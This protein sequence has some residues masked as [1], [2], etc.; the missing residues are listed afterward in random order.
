MK[1][2]TRIGVKWGTECQYELL[3]CSLTDYV[4]TVRVPA[5]PGRTMTDLFNYLYTSV[6]GCPLPTSEFGS[7]CASADLWVWLLR[8]ADACRGAPPKQCPPPTM[9][10]L[11]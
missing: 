3:S 10:V 11:K 1:L 2:L 9:S 7:S 5:A 6:A 8:V 4:W